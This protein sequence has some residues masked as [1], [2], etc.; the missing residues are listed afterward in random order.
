M[1]P[2]G[3]FARQSPTLSAAEGQASLGHDRAARCCVPSV[4]LVQISAHHYLGRAMARDDLPTGTVTFLFTDVEGSTKLLRKLGA[5]AYSK[6]LA[7]H[8]RVL[9]EAFARHGGVEVD[10][11]GD[12]FFYAFAEAKDAAAAAAEAQEALASG[13]IQVRMGIHT[14]EPHLTEEG[15]V[16]EDVHKG[17]RIA[18]A[19]HGSQVLLSK[20]TRELVE[21][22]VADLGEHR[23]KD[24]SEPVWIFQLGRERFPPLKTISNTNLPRPASSFVGREREV[25]EVVSLLRDDARLLTLTGPGGSGKTRLGIEAA[26]ELVSEFRNGVFWVG[27]AALRDPALVTETVAQTVGAKDGLAEHIGEREMLLLLDNFEQVVDA[28]PGLSPLLQ[29]CP[30]LRLLVTS[31]ELLR[32]QGEVEYAVPPL[33]EPEAVEL[34]CTRSGFAPDETIAELCRRLD[35]LPLAVELAAAR[36]SVLSPAQTL[37]RLSKRL[38]LLKGGRDAEVRQRTLRATIEWSFDLLSAEEKELFARLAVFGGGCT[39]ASAEAVAEANLDVLQ[40]LVDK[41]LLRHTEDRFWMLETIREY[42]L[43]RLEE[44]RE[45]EDLLSLAEEAEPHLREEMLRGGTDWFDR[46]EREVDNLRGALDW[47]EGSSEGE[48]AQRLAGAS[49]EFWCGKEHVA[50]GRRRLESALQADGRPTAARAKALIGAAHMA[51]DRGNASLA[52][53]RAAEALALYQNLEE[54][55]GFLGSNSGQGRIPPVAGHV[56]CS[57]EGLGPRRGRTAVRLESALEAT[58]SL[59]HVLLPAPELRRCSRQPLRRLSLAR[60]L[61]PVESAPE[62]VDLPLQSVEPIRAAPKHLLAQVRLRLL[63]Q[64]QE[65]L[66]VAPTQVLGLARFLKPLEGVLPDRLQ[67]PEPVLGMAQQ[68]L[69]H[70]GLQDVEVGLCHGL[71]GLQGAAASE[72]GEAREQL[73]LLSRE[74]VEGPLDHGPKGP[75]ADLGVPAAFEQVQALRQSLQYLSRGEHPRPRRGELHSERQVIQAPAELG[76]RLVRSE[77]RAGAEELRGLRLREGRHRVLDLSLDPEQFPAGDEH[78]QA[79]TALEQRGEAGGRIHHLL[80]VVEQQEHLPLPDVLG[81]AVFGPHGLGDGLGDQ[82]GVAQCRQADPEHP[83]SELV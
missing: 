2:L 83:I 24:F 68:A 74:E 58:P 16:G 45:A 15:Y 61:E 26:A 39:L 46:L 13:P 5:E 34:F 73:L 56:R 67:H 35:D 38:D 47:L 22:E 64:G 57:D 42:A 23:V 69:V 12:A 37:E 49:A 63:G 31:R 21:L 30:S 28:A 76:D 55:E 70:E 71:R 8:R 41:S 60:A 75:L 29:A 40:S 6:A 18:S 54:G 65:V 10:T 43:E 66:G 27:L 7:E 81:Q 78:A 33:A 48:A 82:G 20:E 50:E 11:Q 19:G 17:A 44:S 53:I 36:T 80:E 3:T 72:H 1:K 52:R 4:A 59:R 9:R 77:A 32:V 62:V 51:R 25:A 79:G 14:G